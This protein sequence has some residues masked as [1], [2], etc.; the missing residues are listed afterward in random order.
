[1]VIT[2]S[3]VLYKCFELLEP[4]KKVLIFKFF[5]VLYKEAPGITH[6]GYIVVI[7]DE[8]ESLDWISLLGHIRMATTTLKVKL[9]V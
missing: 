3:C 1:M 2:V 6:S 4:S 9:N 8:Q 7:K 5:L